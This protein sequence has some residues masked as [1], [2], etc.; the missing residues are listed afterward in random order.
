MSDLMLKFVQVKEAS[1]RSGMR[2]R[3]RERKES[4]N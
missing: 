3:E 2:E 1:K 4:L